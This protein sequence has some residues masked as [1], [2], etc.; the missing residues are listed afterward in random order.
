MIKKHLKL[1]IVTTIIIL[2]PIAAGLILWQQLPEQIPSHWNVKGEVDGWASK[3]FVVFSLPMILAAAQWFCVIVTSVDPKGKNHT[4]KM[5][6]LVLWIIPLLSVILSVLTYATALGQNIRVELVMPM[7]MGVLFVIIGN[8]LPKCKQNYTIGIKIA[9]TLNSEENWNKTHRLAGW[10]W[11]I[12]GLI[13]IPTAFVGFW[14][15]LPITL[16]MVIVPLIYSYSL[17]KKGI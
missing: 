2:L 17:Y 16:V 13:M 1:L 10:L 7:V 9:W 11:T 6:G 4:D 3:P 8:Y 5:M 15:M 12:S 14:V